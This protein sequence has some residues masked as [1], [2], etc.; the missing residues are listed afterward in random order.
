MDFIKILPLKQFLLC[1]P[2]DEEALK[3]EPDVLNMLEKMDKL[4][5]W[6]AEVKDLTFEQIIFATANNACRLML[7]LKKICEEFVEKEDQSEEY[8]NEDVEEPEQVLLPSRTENCGISQNKNLT[9]CNNAQ[10]EK[11]LSFEAEESDPDDSG[12]EPFVD[13]FRNQNV[14][15]QSLRSEFFIQ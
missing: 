3:K 12:F 4:I 7:K 9:S 14:E 8:V 6:I 10:Q 2:N 13:M 1:S 11:Q 5:E 15:I